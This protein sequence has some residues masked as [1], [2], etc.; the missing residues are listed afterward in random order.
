MGWPT[1]VYPRASNVLSASSNVSSP[2]EEVGVESP[3]VLLTGRW[4]TLG[5]FSVRSTAIMF[6]AATFEN[7]GGWPLF[8]QIEVVEQFN[9]ATNPDLA[10]SLGDI[11]Q[12]QPSLRQH[13]PG[14]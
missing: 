10:G 12:A 11:N 7:P 1:G 5:V 6:A 3:G 2:D 14:F 9:I 8:Q 4:E 13:V